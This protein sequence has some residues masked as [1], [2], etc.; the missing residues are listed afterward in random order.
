MHLH[1]H[2][3]IASPADYPDV[4]PSISDLSPNLALNLGLPKSIDRSILIRPN[5]PTYDAAERGFTDL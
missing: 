4:A 1:P 5:E 3:P 2:R